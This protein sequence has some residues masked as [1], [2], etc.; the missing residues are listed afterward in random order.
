VLSWLVCGLKKSSN[1]GKVHIELTCSKTGL[2]STRS[3]NDIKTEVLPKERSGGNGVSCHGNKE[4]KFLHA[5]AMCDP[6]PG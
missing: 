2:S 5:R 6:A 4:R 3:Y 1:D